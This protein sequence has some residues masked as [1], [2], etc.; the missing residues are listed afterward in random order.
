MDERFF[1]IAFYLIAVALFIWLAHVLLYHRW[2]R[3]EW[4]RITAGVSIVLGLT[5][6]LVLMDMADAK[7]LLLIFF[8]F[9]SAGAV[10]VSCHIHEQNKVD[11]IKLQ[12]LAWDDTEANR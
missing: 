5:V 4:A 8:G 1:W 3:H 9:F 7:T 12:E 6:P 11:R 10:T 2:K